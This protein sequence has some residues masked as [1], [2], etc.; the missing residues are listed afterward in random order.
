[1]YILILIHI[2]TC[3]D[4]YAYVFI[5]FKYFFICLERD[6][7]IHAPAMPLSPQLPLGSNA[8]LVSETP[9]CVSALPLPSSTPRASKPM[10]QC[11]II[12]YYITR[13]V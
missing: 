1:M 2:H 9:Q 13:N 5:Y 4:N 12:W 3:I 7:D 6:T 10:M 11:N 8:Q